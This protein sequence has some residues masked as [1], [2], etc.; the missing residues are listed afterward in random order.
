MQWGIISPNSPSWFSDHVQLCY[1]WYADGNA[2][3]CGGGAPTEMCAQVGS[4]TEKYRDDTDGR[5]GGCNMA[6]K[7][8]IPHN[9]PEW[10]QSAKL[11]YTWR[12]GS[13][14]GGSGTPNELCAYANRYTNYYRDDTDS[15]S[16][17]CDMSWSLR[18]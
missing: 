11:C 8:S 16:G 4:F 12:G 17:G 9:S 14:C 13:Q 5:S 10:L 1:T 15:R 7:L 18:L 2:G 6:W 3:Q